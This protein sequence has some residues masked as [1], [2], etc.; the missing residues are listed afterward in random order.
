M[1]DLTP[2]SGIAAQDTIIGER[3]PPF[4]MSGT[5]QGHEERAPV[6]RAPPLSCDSHFHVFGPAERYPYG[7]DVRYQPPLALTRIT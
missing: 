3:D 4:S 1:Q 7:S 2:Y 5:V 6:F